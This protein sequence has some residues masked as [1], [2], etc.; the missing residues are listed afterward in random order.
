MPSTIA[1]AVDAV[2]EVSC[3]GAADGAISVTAS[4]GT[5]TLSYARDNGIGAVEDPVLFLPA[6]TP[7]PLQM[8]TIAAR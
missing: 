5:G 7:S 8:R 1:L 6:V 2:T 4:G 3:N